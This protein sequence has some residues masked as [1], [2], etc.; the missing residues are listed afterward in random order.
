MAQSVLKVDR[1]QEQWKQVLLPPFPPPTRASQS[2][3]LWYVSGLMKHDY[4]RCTQTATNLCYDL[5]LPQSVNF[6]RST[7]WGFLEGKDF[8]IHAPAK[9][10]RHSLTNVPSACWI[11]D[12]RWWQKSISSGNQMATKSLPIFCTTFSERMGKKGTLFNG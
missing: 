3:S 2:P 11:L 5:K 7:Y 1:R 4:Y 9:M 8:T 6:Y 12:L 10:L